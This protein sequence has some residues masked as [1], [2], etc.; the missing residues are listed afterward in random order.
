MAAGEGCEPFGRSILS[1]IVKNGR[2]AIRGQDRQFR[3]QLGDWMNE[4]ESSTR[5]SI[6]L[7]LATFCLIFYGMGASFIESFV[8]YPTW[9]MIGTKEF[10][11]YHN[12]AG[13]RIIFYLVVPMLLGTLLNTLL[14]WFRPARIPAWALWLTLGLQL[15]AWISTALIQLPIQFQLG[16]EGLSLPAIDRLLVTNFW[17]RRV[18]FFITSVLFIWMMHVMLR[19]NIDRSEREELI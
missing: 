9:P 10:V 13:P 18:P 15:I 19:H 14:L 12:A 5:F 1:S 7:F 4:N 2:I 8:N 17:F 11:A 16:S 6:W 3:F